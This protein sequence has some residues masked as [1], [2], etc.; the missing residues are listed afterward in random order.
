MDVVAG[1]R[2]MFVTLYSVHYADVLA[3][4]LRRTKPSEA[5]DVVAEAFLV[6]WRRGDEM[7]S[8]P[9]PWLYGV[10]RRI[11]ANRRRGDLRRA[12]L[13]SRLQQEMPLWE[14]AGDPAEEVA[15]RQN[16]LA[17]LRRL[18]E[19]DR[20]LLM[21]L[22]WEELDAS[23]AAMVLGCSR[24]VFAVRLHRARTRFLKEL[25]RGEPVRDEQRGR[26]SSPLER[27]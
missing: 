22:A 6:L 23:A 12:A 21:L 18:R 17:A 2:E 5:E 16:A 20:E 25:E 15:K 13:N 10:A 7:P 19:E 3:Y 11:L 27:S 4:A 14:I 26:S 24:R 1:R 8:D 9:L